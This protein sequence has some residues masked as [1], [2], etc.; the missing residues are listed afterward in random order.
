MMGQPGDDGE[1]WDEY[2]S[3]INFFNAFPAGPRKDATFQTK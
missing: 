1:G 2:F 3:E